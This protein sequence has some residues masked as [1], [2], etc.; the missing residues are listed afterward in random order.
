M[1]GIDEIHCARHQRPQ[2]RGS[3]RPGVHLAQFVVVQNQAKAIGNNQQRY[4]RRVFE[5]QS[6]GAAQIE[7]A[8]GH[9]TIRGNLR[10]LRAECGDSVEIGFHPGD[11]GQIL[12]GQFGL[13][14]QRGEPK[15]QHQRQPQSL[16]EGHWL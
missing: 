7:I 1:A 6:A 5:P 10:K 14:G 3:H 9:L 2:R 12:F 16:Y 11:V 15:S 13:G 8:L 4:R